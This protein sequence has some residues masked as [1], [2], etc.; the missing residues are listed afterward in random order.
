MQATDRT[1]SDP[2]TMPGPRKRKQDSSD[3]FVKDRSTK[4]LR[5]PPFKAR[6]IKAPMSDTPNIDA[7]P[8]AQTEPFNI[9]PNAN[10]DSRTKCTD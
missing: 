8:D 1:V 10:C 7:I 2:I 6:K 4:K 9:C 5:A 3:K